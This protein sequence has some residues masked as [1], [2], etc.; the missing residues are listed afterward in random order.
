MYIRPPLHF[1]YK[2]YLLREMPYLSK[3]KKAKT[4]G[5]N[6]FVP[7]SSSGHSKDLGSKKGD[8]EI[9]KDATA[10]KTTPPLS[11]EEHKKLMYRLTDFISAADYLKAIKCISTAEDLGQLEEHTE[12]V[13]ARLD[14][15]LDALSDV[16]PTE[17]D[18]EGSSGEETEEYG[19]GSEGEEDS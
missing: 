16:L 14:A 5:P 7:P 8:P 17:K 9:A 1:A 12:S 2:C 15:F 19:E 6:S 13:A 4:D 10:P 18:P 3:T 11:K